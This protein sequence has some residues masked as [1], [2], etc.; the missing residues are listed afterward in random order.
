MKK[1]IKAGIAVILTLA[2]GLGVTACGSTNSSQNSA[3]STSKQSL[4]GKDNGK[5]V[6]FGVAPGPYGDMVKL[7]IQP[8]LEKKGYTVKLMEFSDYVQPNIALGNGEI[9]VNL[10]QHTVYLENFAKEHNLDL[11]PVISVPT[12]SMGIFSKKY[13]KLGELPDGATVTLPNDVPNLARALRFLV[14]VNLI[15]LKPDIDLTKASERDIAENPKKLVFTPA[16]AAQLPRTLDSADIAI[17]N[18]NFAISAGL[19]L[20]D[21]VAKEKLDES[22]KNIIAV[23]TSDKE[24]QFV[25]DIEEIVKS[26]E[27]RNVIKDDKNVFKDFDFPE[28]FNK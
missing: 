21:A 1:I 20:S 13:K 26:Q 23:K 8:E 5:E 22:Y 19:K 12:A 18:G 3:D 17:I 25:K 27:F 16:E 14:Q 4:S 10:F 24:T 6:V 11:S 2:L 9:N 7:A 15:T 28:W